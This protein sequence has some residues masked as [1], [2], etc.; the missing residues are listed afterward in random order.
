VGLRVDAQHDGV[1]AIVEPAV[2]EERE[3]VVACGNDTW[4]RERSDACETTGVVP[5]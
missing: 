5:L 3:V 4:W 2:E 1:A